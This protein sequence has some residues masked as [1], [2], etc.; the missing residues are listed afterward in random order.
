MLL[1][2][3][4][5]KPGI[6]ILSIMLTVFSARL[7]AQLIITTI[8]G[9]G[10]AAYG[11]DGGPATTAILNNPYGIAVDPSGNIFIAD[12]ANNRIR[13][14]NS[15]GI[16]TTIAGTGFSGFTG[17]G[18][19]ATNAK[20][21]APRGITS[22]NAG[23]IFF[24]D[25]AN[26]RIRKITTTGIIST[27]A[28]NGL[29][30]FSGDGGQATAAQLNFAWGVG[31]DALGNLYIADQMNCRIRKVNTSGII[32]TIGGT[33][34]AFFS[35]DG[36][37]AVSA[38]IQYPMGLVVDG[39]GNVYIC[40]E[41][42][43]RIRKINTAGIISTIAGNGSAGFTGDGGPATLAKLYY[44]QGITLDNS[45]NVYVADLNNNRIREINTSGVINTITGTGVAG[46]SGDG[47]PP[48]LAEINQSTGVAVDAAGI[49]YIADNDNNRIREIHIG[50]HAP[51]FT[52]G[53]H[54]ALS[55][56]PVESVDLDSLLMVFDIDT[57]QTETWNVILPPMHG[58]LSGVYSTLSTGANLLPS[59]YIYIPAPG[60][61]GTDSV[62]I[63]VN[64]GT[65]SDTTTIVFNILPSPDAGIISGADSLCPFDTLTFRDTVSG[66][67]W[68]SS[69]TSVAGISGSGLVGSLTPGFTDIIYTITN[70]CGTASANF[71]LFIK[72]DCK[73][74]FQN[75]YGHSGQKIT[76]SPNPNS[77]FFEI[78]IITDQPGDVRY[79]ISNIIGEKVA[80]LSTT[81]GIPV[82]FRLD[83]PAGI[84]FVSAVTAAGIW[85][86][87]FMIIK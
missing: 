59:G 55:F 41:G 1:Y 8:A 56:C 50:S 29:P 15:A 74:G 20:I 40:D 47:G 70:V 83:K 73:T 58:S 67:A 2:K 86:S 60:Y 14:I 42:D 12:Y 66:G 26:N 36:G 62:K 49:I 63:R 27:V 64:D 72:S 21:Y 4:C 11:G 33:G 65:F 85:E 57:G 51:Y 24:S 81:S 75:I 79:T 71:P 76:I 82:Q 7:Q 39:P 13:K 25:Y 46:Y 34:I 35:G 31:V 18:G 17:D 48:S 6:L 43:C 77:G 69:N 22:D 3:A 68:S 28:G 23:N 61:A 38:G 84:Y 10:A 87:K 54:Q 30:G 80:T 78:N 9:T 32:S 16:I 52:H 5:S 45:G 53:H 44:P 37:P 19:P